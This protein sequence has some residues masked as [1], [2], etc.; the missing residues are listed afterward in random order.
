MRRDKGKR[1]HVCRVVDA[2]FGWLFD[3]KT[4]VLN[5]LEA[6]LVLHPKLSRPPIETSKWQKN[7]LPPFLT[8]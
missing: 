8:R 7:P 1:Q 5:C 4:R 2:L 6:R 3:L